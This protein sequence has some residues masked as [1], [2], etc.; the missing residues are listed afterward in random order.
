[1]KH[2]RTNA[3][4]DVA[5]AEEPELFFPEVDTPCEN[6]NAPGGQC[7][8]NAVSLVPDVCLYC[9]KRTG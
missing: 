1:M 4:S 5:E 2:F 9:R 7:H 8:F 6:P 3:P